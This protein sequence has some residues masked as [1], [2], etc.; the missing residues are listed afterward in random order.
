MKK[1]YITAVVI[2]VVAVFAA[3][4]IITCPSC[5]ASKNS[6]IRKFGR[7]VV[8]A[9]SWCGM[10]DDKFL[11]RV[12]D[13]A[14]PENDC[15]EPMEVVDDRHSATEAIGYCYE[16]LS[17]RLQGEVNKGIENRFLSPRSEYEAT[18][19]SFDWRGKISDPIVMKAIL[20]SRELT[21]IAGERYFYTLCVDSE[22]R[23]NSVINAAL[24]EAIT[25]RDYAA[26]ERIL[27][28]WRVSPLPPQPE[29]LKEIMPLQHEGIQLELKRYIRH[30]EWWIK[31]KST[32]SAPCIK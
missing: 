15:E 10:A 17:A 22:K 29:C 1:R 3:F 32:T 21:Q 19:Y 27:S 31:H 7:I 20:S 24:K 26:I 18:L 5:V 23:A 11:L 30:W 6:Q 13:A 12:W 16:K 28:I 2:L 14:M 4:A 8:Y 9:R 25:N